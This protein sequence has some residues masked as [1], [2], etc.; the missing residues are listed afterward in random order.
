M[1]SLNYF[2]LPQKFFIASPVVFHHIVY[3]FRGQFRFG[4]NL[5]S[6]RWLFKSFFFSLRIGNSISTS[7]RASLFSRERSFS[8][9][10]LISPFRALPSSENTSSSGSGSE[11]AGVKFFNCSSASFLFLRSSSRA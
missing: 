11:G 1:Y 5:S 2:S 8:F 3:F 6:A 9:R 10:A 7:L 4:N